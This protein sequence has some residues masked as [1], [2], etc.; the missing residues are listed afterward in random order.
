MGSSSVIIKNAR[1]IDPAQNLDKVSDLYISQGIIVGIDSAPAGFSSNEEVDAKDQW[2][3]PAFIDLCAN[4]GQ[5]GFEQKG[6][7]ASETLAAVSAGIATLVCPP[8]TKPVVDSPAVA[9]LIQEIAEHEGHCE[10]RPLG[11]MTQGLEGE[12]LSEMHALYEAGCVGFSNGHAPIRNTRT[13]LRCLEYAATLELPVFFN[14]KDADLAEG[15]C[16]HM[17]PTSTRLGLVGIPASAETIAVSKILLLVEQ[18]GVKAHF[19]QLSVARSVELIA[20]AQRQGLPVT[21]GVSVKQLLLT[22]ETIDGFNSFYHVQPP[23]R[24]ET[25]RLA[26]IEGVNKGVISAICS[27]HTP[28]EAAAKMAP[29]AETQP[30][31]S[32]F[33]SFIPSCL[34]LVRSGEINESIIIERLVNGPANILG[35]TPS[36]LTVNAPATFTLINPSTEVNLSAGNLLSAGHNNS[37]LGRQLTGQAS[38]TYIDGKLVFPQ[39]ANDRL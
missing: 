21:A 6:T 19:T 35:S 4:T 2:L 17:G 26:L 5:P 36:S 25:D 22:D 14:A 39:D 33:D 1:L 12:Q 23:Y 15:G 30:G 20:A 32:I 37:D 38:R 28:H 3:C 24:T 29:F 18:T 13:L 8:E 11:A 31:M 27:A 9:S 7:I 34:E 10:V 16:V